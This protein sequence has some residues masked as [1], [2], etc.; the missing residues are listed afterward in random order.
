MTAND[1]SSSATARAEAPAIGLDLLAAGRLPP[2][3]SALLRG[4]DGSLLAPL[5][6]LPGPG[7]AAELCRAPAHRPDRRSLA[8]ELAESNRAY[9]HPAASEMARKLADPETLVVV[10]GQQ[11][12]LFGGPLYTFS[13]AVAAARW[14][15]ELEASGRPAVAVF[16]VATEDH[17]Y[18][19]VAHGTFLTPQGLL[20][21]DLGED[22]AP[23]LP[24]GMRGL[25]PRV[26][27][28][29]DQLREA[30]P[31]DRFAAWVDTLA[32]WYRPTARFG[33]AFPRLLVHLLA[34][35]SP[36]MLDAQLPALKRAQAPWME[37]LVRERV[38][39][40]R[41]LA[42][43]DERVQK[44]GYELQV[45]PQPGV[46]PLFLL[47]GS[48]RRR[49]EW[50]AGDTFRL[51]GGDGEKHPVAELYDVLRDNPGVLSPGVLARPALQ[52]AV[53]GTALQVLGPGELS[54]MVQAAA[55]HGFLD[56]DGPATTLRPQTLVLEN[57]H[58]E[59]LDDLGVGLEDLL[60]DHRD[61]DQRLAEA[62]GV[63]FVTPV[64]EQ[65]AE[66]LDGLR[67]P[68]TDVDPNLARPLERT[69][70]QAIGALE[71]LAGKLAAAAARTDETRRRRV[72]TLRELCL[73]HG[74][75]QERVLS[76]A[77]FPGKYGEAL[78]EAY[79]Q[80]MNLDGRNLQVIRL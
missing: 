20:D 46:S 68:V 40:D 32:S 6:W 28:L 5:R 11:P 18:A 15:A 31:G 23:L 53:L 22:T 64:K 66:L 79:W 71:Q 2:I 4:S 34:E 35:R 48:E 33:E 60:G 75:L 80:Q 17:D 50:S 45:A 54:Y 76:S 8:A 74:S 63:D 58:L 72:E 1:S 56:L 13:K 44:A 67:Q 59:W 42:A 36:L 29:L 10:T 51:R 14:A 24:V 70:E 61:L 78:V 7:A 69:R 73:P 16:W 65:I 77:Y 49:I 52:D 62:V 30:I 43:A 9:G 41:A 27:P 25:G 38:A 3:P 26:A 57:R 39:L 47:R 37:R 12:G 21:L 19:E 55:V